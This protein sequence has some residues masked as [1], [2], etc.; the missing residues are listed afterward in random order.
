MASERRLAEQIGIS[1]VTLREALSVLD[2]EGYLT[3][4]RGA[5]GGA[6]VA[7]E[8]AL[9]HMAET[10]FSAGPAAVLRVMEYRDHAEP[11]AARLAALR[12]GPADLK[13]IDAAL[14]GIHAAETAGAIRGGEAVFHLSVAQAAG[15]AFFA[16]SIDDAMAAL[17]LPFPGADAVREAVRSHAVRIAVADA[18]RLR[19]GDAAAAAMRAVLTALRRRFP[20]RQVA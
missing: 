14:A 4:R 15:N 10:Q 2:A 9:R 20:R 12:R 6:F 19:D 16:R 5:A 8:H 13:R 11:E 3:I 7:P 17:F 1:R 18:L